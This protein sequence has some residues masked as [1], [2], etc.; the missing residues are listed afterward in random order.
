MVHIGRRRPS[1]ALVVAIVALVVAASGTALATSRLVSGD[2]LIRK[3]SLSG[4]RLR[5]ATVTGQQIKLSSLGAVPSARTAA[6]AG[7]LGGHAASAFELA[8]NVARSGLVTASGGQTVQLASFGPFTVS[9]Q[10][11]DDGG[12]TFDA[13]IMVSS[14]TAGSEAYGTQMTPGTPQELSDAGPDS[15]F[16]DNAGGLAVDFVAPPA[17][18]MGY[19]TDAIFLPGTTTPCAASILVGKS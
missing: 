3:H 18:Y 9:L 8:S 5:N 1:A 4:D 11:T 10:C 17:A 16:Q 2:K 19:V 15:G 6:D 14:S 7:A 12:G 13:A